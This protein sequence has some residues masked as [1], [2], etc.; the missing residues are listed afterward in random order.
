MPVNVGNAATEADKD[1]AVQ[2][3]NESIGTSVVSSAASVVASYLAIRS[4]KNAS[5]ARKSGISPHGA[6][7]ARVL[8]K[9]DGAA[10]TADDTNQIVLLKKGEGVL[11]RSKDKDILLDAKQDVTICAA[12]EI[13]HSALKNKFEKGEIEHSNFKVLT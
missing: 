2:T 13:K 1:W 7:E 12:N 4:L 9:Q 6:P 3:A 8:L 11:V 5:E 10:I